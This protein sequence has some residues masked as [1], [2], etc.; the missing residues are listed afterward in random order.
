[1]AD[2]TAALSDRDSTFAQLFIL[3]LLALLAYRAWAAPHPK[4]RYLA[5]TAGLFLFT[6]LFIVTLANIILWTP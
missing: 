6:G 1:M 5:Q 3:C 4:R 2:W